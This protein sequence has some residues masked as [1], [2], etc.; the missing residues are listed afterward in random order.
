MCDK[1]TKGQVK[2]EIFPAGQLYD[3]KGAAQAVLMGTIQMVYMSSGK[4]G[5]DRGE[6]L[7]NAPGLWTRDI[8]YELCTG[9]A[10]KDFLKSLEASGLYGLGVGMN[11]MSQGIFSDIGPLNT[12]DDL[13]G[14]KIRIPPAQVPEL[15]V[16]ALG[17]SPIAIPYAEL[18]PALERGMVDGVF[19]G[20]SSGISKGLHEILDYGVSSAVFGGSLWQGVLNKAFWDSLT[21]ELQDA[22][23]N[24]VWPE[25]AKWNFAEAE[26]DEIELTNKAIAAMKHV[27]RMES[28]A[29][30]KVWADALVTVPG[31][32]LNEANPYTADVVIKI[33]GYKK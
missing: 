31:D 24:K 28:A 23:E 9:P 7:L 3:S 21:P 8:Y 19:T 32:L 33:T 29:E 30:M 11:T 5:I 12:P 25:L 2:V 10:G 1:Y 14:Q 13:V 27:N 4:L 22:I 15:I 26:K 16:G 18:I 6:N 17:A 20:W